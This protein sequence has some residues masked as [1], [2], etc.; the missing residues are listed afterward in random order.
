[1]GSHLLEAASLKEAE[2]R[3]HQVRSVDH[4]TLCCRN[5][6]TSSMLFSV[7]A[8]INSLLPMVHLSRPFCYI[9]HGAVCCRITERKRF[10][11]MS[12]SVVN[13]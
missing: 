6:D 13:F 10:S 11:W 3:Q 4:Y 12:L 8:R 1:M 7:A 2:S 9:W 5:E